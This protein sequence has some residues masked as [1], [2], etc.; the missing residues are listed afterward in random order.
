MQIEKQN[1]YKLKKGDQIGRP[2]QF[3]PFL[4]FCGGLLYCRVNFINGHSS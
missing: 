4:S 1:G 2:M 3:S